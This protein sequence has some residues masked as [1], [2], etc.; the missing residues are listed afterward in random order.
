MSTQSF[1]NKCI[2]DKNNRVVIWQGPN[3]P[4]IGWL[5][6]TVAARIFDTRSLHAGFESLGTAFLFT[7]AYLE[8]TQ[9][10]SYFRRFLGVLVAIAIV[11]HFFS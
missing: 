6:C 1:I 5:M 9:G 8:I 2:R 10:L 4:I 7:W 11:V 3:L